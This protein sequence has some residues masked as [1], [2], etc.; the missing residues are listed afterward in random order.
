MWVFWKQQ[1]VEVPC[2]EKNMPLFSI[3]EQIILL[4]DKQKCLSEMAKNITETFLPALEN[5]L[6]TMKRL[7]QKHIS[8]TERYFHLRNNTIK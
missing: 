2:A 8:S 1:E 7:V 5:E 4:L 6:N 3:E